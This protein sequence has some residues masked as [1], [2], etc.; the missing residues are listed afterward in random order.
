MAKYTV[1]PLEDF[2]GGENMSSTP[3][4]LLNNQSRE[5]INMNPLLHGGVISRW[6][7]A[8][9]RSI[10]GTRADRYI[11]FEYITGST[12]NRIDI[13]LV[14]GELRNADTGA[15]IKTGLDNYMSYEV[16]DNKLYILSNGL[17]FY[18]DG[19]TCTDVTTAEPESDNMLPSV[20]KCRY[21]IQRGDRF[22]AAGNP[23]KP[24]EL[25]YSQPFDPTSWWTPQKTSGSG[26]PMGINPIRAVSDD[27]DVITG[28]G[29][30][31]GA[32]LVFKVRRVYAWYNFDPLNDV[33]FK[34]LDVASGTIAH[35]SICNVEN[36][37]VYLGANGVY[38][39]T[40][41]YQ[42]VIVTE[43][44]SKNVEPLIDRITVPTTYHNSNICAVYFDNKYFLSVPVDSETD[45]SL[46]L[47]LHYDVTVALGS[48]SWSHYEN[49]KFN[50]M[51][52]GYD[53]KFR[54]I[55]AATPS[56]I[57][58]DDQYLNDEGGLLEFKIRFRPV[59][60]AGKEAFYIKKFRS[61]F[62]VAKQWEGVSSEFE[63]GGTVDYTPLSEFV[64]RTSES[65]VWDKSA[66]DTA[67]WDFSETVLT[68]GRLSARGKR[69]DLEIK[70]KELDNKILIYKLGIEYKVK[71]LEK[72]RATIDGLD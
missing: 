48:P 9:E 4:L 53:W 35:R 7:T 41:T 40:G 25:Y 28:L 44:L 64:A 11:E 26:L 65:M 69:L 68:G 43:L 16:L 2:S 20:K 59:F 61:I 23:E 56:I 30:L 45:N 34:P 51:F 17:F 66:W 42:N 13:M 15:V 52:I 32:L 38:R 27:G 19:T 57:L 8:V 54:A 31:H 62:I 49:L 47:V 3:D 12:R 50:D 5:L 18:F 33:E 39:L 1:I 71:K 22:F 36:S 21:I 24:N 14:D 67:L 63:I 10:S 29:K 37:L 70:A 58:M 46:I 55:K 6:G 72:V 60:I